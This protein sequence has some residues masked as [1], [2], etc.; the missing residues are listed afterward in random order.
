MR[1][2]IRIGDCRFG[3]GVFARSIIRKGEEILCFSGPLISLE[4]ALAKGERQCDPLQIGRRLYMDIGSPGVL[5]NH[6]CEP[7][8]G[9]GHDVS[10]VAITDIRAG[11]EIFYDYSTTMDEDHWTLGCLCGSALCRVNVGDFKYLP[12]HTRRKYLRIGIVQT[13][14]ACQFI[15]PEGKKTVMQKPEKEIR[16]AGRKHQLALH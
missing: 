16:A 11:E 3:K 7:N 1:D 15:R 10:L 12:L 6:S 9:I 13:Y 5:V 14:L 8:A 2:K 4:E